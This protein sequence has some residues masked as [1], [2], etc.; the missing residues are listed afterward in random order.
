MWYRVYI[1]DSGGHITT[2]PYEIEADNDEQALD[3]AW[4]MIEVHAVDVWQGK[5]QV[6]KLTRAEGR[7]PR[8]RR[9]S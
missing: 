2:P 9:S 7:H 6:G 5:R 8:T 4:D 1:L 3:A